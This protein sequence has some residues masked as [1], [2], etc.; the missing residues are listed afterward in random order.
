MG[1]WGL[2]IN[3]SDVPTDP[4]DSDVSTAA[5][6]R[7]MIVESC[8]AANRP[9][10]NQLVHN[11][12][13]GMN[14]KHPTEKELVSAI[15]WWVKNHVSFA[16]DEPV[17]GTL[18]FVDT[19][20]ELLINPEVLVSMPQPTGD[21]D[22]YSMLIAAM[23]KCARIPVWFVTI[24]VDPAEPFRF[25]HVYCCVEVDGVK[26]PLDASHGKYPGWETRRPIYRRVEWYVG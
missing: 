23:C 26:V 12:V 8:W 1:Y 19:N 13:V 20:R 17:V 22:D 6:I 11:L 4:R 25:S 21:C 7:Q 14:K 18:G 2:P 9:L 5:T 15:Y 10:I 16:E 3:I 24:A